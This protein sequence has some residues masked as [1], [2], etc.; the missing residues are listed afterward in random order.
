MWIV[1]HYA[2]APDQPTGTRHYALARAVVREGAQATIFAAGFSHGIGTGVDLS[3]QRL[4]HATRYGGVTFVWLWTFPYFGN[5][6]RRMVNMVSFAVVLVV[7]QMV[8]RRPDVIVGST[9]HP[10]AALAAW[11][12]SRIRRAR[13]FFEIRDLW[14]QTLVDLGAMRPSSPIARVL[15]VIESFLVRRAEVV[16]TLLPGVVDYLEGRGLP[17]DHVVYLPNGVDLIDEAAVDRSTAP[18]DPAAER[19]IAEMQARRAGGSLVL[20]YLGAHGRVNRLDVVLEAFARART[21]TA[22][23][24]TLLLV[25]DGPEKEDLVD[26]A[27]SLGLDDAAVFADPVAKLRVPD[28]LSVVDVGVDPHHEDA[29]LPLRHQ[30]QQALRLHGGED[31]DRLRDEHGLRPHRGLGRGPHRRAGRSRGPCRGARAVR[32]DDAR[33]P[34]GDG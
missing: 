5:T 3:G 20:G 25:G 34:P 11:F 18:A 29:R 1:N 13:F 23:P 27:R 15:W 33:G 24:M 4:A 14:P 9:V 30:L 16:I 31:P 26:L 10:F 7:A 12:V 32:R 19:L 22:T 21:A 8:R 17:S 2:G 28:L 6:W